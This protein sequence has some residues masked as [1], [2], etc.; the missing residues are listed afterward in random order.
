[1]GSAPSDRQKTS[2][3]GG[4]HTQNYDSKENFMVQIIRQ[5]EQEISQC[6]AAVEKFKSECADL[7]LTIVDQRSEIQNLCNK[8]KQAH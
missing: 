1:M 3:S 7:E 5:Q 2:S 8:L 6:N 4:P